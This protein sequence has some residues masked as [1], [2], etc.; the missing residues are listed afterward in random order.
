MKHIFGLILIII[1]GYALSQI[2]LVE[3]TNLIISWSAVVG[4]TSMVGMGMLEEP[5]E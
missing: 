5:N 1:A 4:L 2:F 3:S